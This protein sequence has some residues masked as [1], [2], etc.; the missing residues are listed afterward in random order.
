MGPQL[1]LRWHMHVRRCNRG[2]QDKKKKKKKLHLVQVVS[3]LLLSWHVHMRRCI[4]G[5][6]D[7][8]FHG[9]G[10]VRYRCC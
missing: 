10:A 7:R 2:E 4:R 5:K 1:L 9:C 8:W 6:Q 3:R